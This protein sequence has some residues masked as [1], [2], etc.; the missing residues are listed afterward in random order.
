MKAKPFQINALVPQIKNN[1]KGALIFGP[2]L[3]VVQEISE[4]TSVSTATISRVSK[5]LNYGSGGYKKAIE[6]LGDK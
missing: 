1:F 4:K 2:D 5:C 3:G 6:N